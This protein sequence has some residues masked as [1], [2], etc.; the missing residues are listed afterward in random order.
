MTKQS[1]LMGA[2]ILF[3][4]SLFNRILSFGYRVAIIRIV[5]DEGI[6][7]YEMVFPIYV[8][9]LVLATAGIPLAMSKLVS[10]E[11]A[12]NN[13]AGAYKIMKIATVF[14]MI[15]GSFFTLGLYLVLPYLVDRAFADPRVYLILKTMI[16]GILLV[17]ISSVFRGFFQGLQ[18]MT[19]TAITQ[20]V[21]QIT[22][23]AVGIYLS[24]LLLPHGLEYG[25]VG[26]AIGMVAGEAVGLLTIY[27]IYRRKRP[28]PPNYQSSLRSVTILKNIHELSI[29]I[30]LTRIVSSVIMSIEAMLIPQRLQAAGFTFR[31]ATSLYG[32][33][34]GIAMSL[35]VLP[36]V[37]TISLAVT[38]IPSISEA[39]AKNNIR[40][41]QQRTML[42][43][44]MT[45]MIGIP[46][47]LVFFVL[48]ENF[49]VALFNNREAGQ[50]L[51]IL[52]LGGVFLY[53]HQTCS[54]I[55]QGLGEVKI[56]LINS[57]V[58]GAIRL[59]GIYLLAAIPSYGIKGVA[60]AVNLSF[61]T[62]A[63]LNLLALG[64]LVNFELDVKNS[65]V[66]PLIASL[67]MLL[68]IIQ[69]KKQLLVTGSDLGSL[70][71]ICTAAAGVYFLMLVLT[72]AVNL[73]S[74]I[75]RL[76]RW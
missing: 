52:A 4:A 11:M 26:I 34:S 72:G 39:V 30:T 1:I 48:A 75:L 55:L 28:T 5:G 23:V 33:Y 46:S 15:S 51:R 22:R 21:E 38:L 71:L 35:L 45:F 59:G 63:F 24:L 50:V 61:L 69:L 73:K 31:E 13:I 44:A 47:A 57:I 62:V 76:K 29:P 16:P 8:M 27:A 65:I 43:I 68:V 17:S 70:L 64:K 60:I 41:I 58:G 36:T 14:L 2:A 12:K 42:S 3:I 20:I 10:A 54:G 74:I 53:L 25:V 32:Q 37:F 40:S 67:V 9:V 49:T 66:K 18:Q 56:P 7:L 6:G 19:P